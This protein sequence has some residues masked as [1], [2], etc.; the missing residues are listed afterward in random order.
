MIYNISCE[1]LS[2]HTY[3]TKKVRLSIRQQ[4]TDYGQLVD[5]NKKRKSFYE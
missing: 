2:K 3:L 4:T 5:W 1:I